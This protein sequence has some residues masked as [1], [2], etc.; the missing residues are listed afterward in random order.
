ML[1]LGVPIPRSPRTSLEE[2]LVQTRAL[3]V[4]EKDEPTTTSAMP[5]RRASSP[6]IL[7]F[8]TYHLLQI[9]DPERM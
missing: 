7:S 4:E 1:T 8:V 2:G 5:F 9:Q 6:A 3:L